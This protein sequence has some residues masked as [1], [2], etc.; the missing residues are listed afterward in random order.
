MAREPHHFTW[1][2]FGRAIFGSSIIGMTF[3]FKG[4]M[5][6]YAAKMRPLNVFLVIIFTLIVV[7]IEIYALSYRF[8]SDRKERPFYE[9]WAKR[10]FAVT[11]SS[12]TMIYVLI[13]LYGLNTHLTDVEMF[14]L[15]SAIFMPA[16]VAGAA[17]EM[18][19]K[20]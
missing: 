10:F 5:F 9:F 15:A 14:K 8:V 2:D 6:D 1:E 7:T 20:R 12:F 16:S 17:V 18:L 13:Y 19:K 4:S 11:I 3:L